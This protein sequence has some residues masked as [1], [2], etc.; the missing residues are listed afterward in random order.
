[1]NLENIKNDLTITVSTHNEEGVKIT[2]ETKVNTEMLPE[3]YTE[4]LQRVLSDNI[5][6][7]NEVIK[8]H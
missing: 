1:M 8:E 4:L 5:N 2:V 3:T 7:L 6:K